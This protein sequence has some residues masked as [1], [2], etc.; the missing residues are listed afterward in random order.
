MK[1]FTR[2]QTGAEGAESGLFLGGGC[3]GGGFAFCVLG[4]SFVHYPLADRIRRRF[5]SITERLLKCSVEKHHF[6]TLPRSDGRHVCAL[7]LWSLFQF[8]LPKWC[9]PPGKPAGVW[10][11]DICLKAFFT[12]EEINSVILELSISFK[13]NH[14]FFVK[15]RSV[16]SDFDIS[17][18]YLFYSKYFSVS[19]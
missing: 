6:S 1:W 19:W 2:S 11:S 14:Y 18:I 12:Q 5:T 10:W 9:G 17:R 13:L 4:V 8:T 15:M 7:T 16:F 3:G